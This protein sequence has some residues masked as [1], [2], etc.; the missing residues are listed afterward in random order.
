MANLLVLANN[1]AEQGSIHE[2]GVPLLPQF[3]SK[4]RPLFG[5]RRKELWVNLRV[6]NTF[7]FEQRIAK[8]FS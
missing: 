5:F 4:Y 8:C 2:D 6:D 3:Q 1:V 7:V